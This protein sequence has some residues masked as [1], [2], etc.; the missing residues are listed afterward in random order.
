MTKKTQSFLDFWL[1]LFPVLCYPSFLLPL[2]V[3]SREGVIIIIAG[4]RTMLFNFAAAIIHWNIYWLKKPHENSDDPNIFS[5]SEKNRLSYFILCKITVIGIWPFWNRL[6]SFTLLDFFHRF[7]YLNYG[8]L[9][10]SNRVQ[11]RIEY[12][13]ETENWFSTTTPLTQNMLLA[14]NPTSGGF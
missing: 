14:E 1:F 5:G 12:L 10:R 8:Y 9:K 2:P 13:N 11:T 3:R 4:L 7:N 6:L